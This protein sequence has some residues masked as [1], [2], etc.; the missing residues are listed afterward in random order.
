MKSRGIGLGRMI[1]LTLRSRFLSL[2]LMLGGVAAVVAL[3][4]LSLVELYPHPNDLVGYAAINSSLSWMSSLVS[5]PYDLETI[6]GVLAREISVVTLLALPVLGIS[7]ASSMTRGAEE[8]GELEMVTA[9]RV[10]R[11]TPLLASTLVIFGGVVCS[12]LATWGLLVALGYPSQASLL[13]CVSLGATILM[14]AG[15]TMV[16]AQIF[17]VSSGVYA[18]MILLVFALYLARGIQEVTTSK[19][20]L[21]NPNAW[22]IIVRPFGSNPAYWPLAA[23]FGV[24]FIG[25]LLA[26][27]LSSH[28][29]LGTGI[30]RP[31]LGRSSAR[32]YLTSPFPLYWRLS[33]QELP[34]CLLITVA[35]SGFFAFTVNKMDVLM[36]DE[37]M[38]KLLAGGQDAL[39]NM[40]A[41]FTAVI[42]AAFGHLLVTR[43]INEE[44]CGR[45][46]IVLA[47]GVGRVKWW[48][49]T[50][51]LVLVQ[52]ALVLLIN[53]LTLGIGTALVLDDWT[54]FNGP[55]M[56]VMGLGLGAGFIVTL[57]MFLAAIRP[58][59][60]QVVWLIVAW[61]AVIGL[62]G[63]LLDIPQWLNYVSPI[64]W[65]G[66]L[67]A[68]QIELGGALGA[69]FGSILL[70]GLSALI[71]RNRDLTK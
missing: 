60:A 17:S 21:W 14:W 24:G 50:T 43:F 53:G 35:Y 41:V 40:S 2:F 55:F 46:G 58:S 29:D 30:I 23:M 52:S 48:I 11:L 57:T 63:A 56:A 32:A 20:A 69:G 66:N 39:I 26:L 54:E 34:I 12:T 1:G 4:G 22:P 62:F 71:F 70:F 68:E 37:T 6:G 27:L 13:Y 19:S 64:Y 51:G 8:S 10:H 9:G 59:F 16:A 47:T 67:P 28:R 3:M 5:I 31:S 42:A 36:Q 61:A 49:S 7:M 18:S 45:L 33:A 25:V 15:L 38:K 65:I 44:T